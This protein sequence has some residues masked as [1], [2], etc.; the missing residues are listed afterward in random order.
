MSKTDH[1]IE[2]HILQH[3][4]HLKHVDELLERARKSTEAEKEP[5]P[6]LAAIEEERDKL[7]GLLRKMQ[8]GQPESWQDSAEAQFGPLAAWNVIARLLEELIERA[9]KRR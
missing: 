6:L 8:G 4:A 7:A 2:Q 1:L 9:E 3:E 5:D